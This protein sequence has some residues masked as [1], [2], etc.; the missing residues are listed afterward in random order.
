[1]IADCGLRIADCPKWKVRCA[2]VIAVLLAISPAI[3]AQETA[4]VSGSVCD[5]KGA[6]LPRTQVEVR[7]MDGRVVASAL[8]NVRGEFSLDLARGRY[9]LTAT[10]AGMAPLRDLPIR[11]GE[12]TAPL[13]LTLEVPPL[14]QQIVVTATKTETPLAQVGSDVTVI[15]GE[16]LAHEGAEGTADALRR[17]AGLT[18]SES[19]G[20]GQITSLFL[21]GGESKYTKVLIDGIA[22][23]EPGGAFNFANLSATAIDHI[24]IV[25]GP[26]SALFGSD[27]IAGVIQIF[28]RRG[29]SEGL[30]PV[31]QFL[32]EGGSFATYR[33]AA[34]IQARSRRLDYFASFSRLDTD[35][36]VP[37]G[38]FNEETIVGNLG[39]RPSTTSEIR[40]VFHSEAG[41]AGV[42]GQW[43]FERPDLDQ[44]YRHRNLAGGI[45]F[46]WSPRPAWNHRFSYT[47]SDSRQFSADPIDSGCFVAQ[48]QGRTAPYTA[49]DFPY[50]T[51]DDTRRQKVNYQSD[52]AL[53]HKNLLTAGADYERE[54]GDIGDPSANPLHAIRDNY[55]AYVQ[56]QWTLGNRL[57]TAAGVRLEHNQ[58][59]GFFAA[60]RL[61]LAVHL[62]QPAPGSFW[63]LTK[64]RA[65]FG[66]GIKEPSLVESFSDSPFFHGNPNLRPERS[67]GYDAG[68]EQNLGK[69]ALQ[70]TWFDTR[71]RDQIGFVVTDYTTFAGTF[72][73]LG[74]TRARGVETMLRQ[75]LGTHWEIAG[76]YTLLDS[77]VLES[78]SP[79][80]VYA[81]GQELLRRPRHSGSLDLRWRPRR[82]LMLGASG[83]LVGS[84]VDS[85]FSGLG[86]TR[87]PGYG[88]LNLQADFKLTESISCFAVVNN[89][90]NR[91]YME[92]LGYPALRAN[93]RIGIRAGL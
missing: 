29:E 16:E 31:P 76:A 72:F 21:R 89:A 44:Y 78:S 75:S 27:A 15:S 91:K 79:D 55:G 52:V 86:M 11:V 13:K 6:P 17:I 32:L 53:P 38:S 74:K 93:F 67:A 46:T 62:H 1:M 85:D 25:R 28:T 26:Q 7:D 8:T 54:S 58:N 87:N 68:I 73:N 19:G 77:R 80:P 61:S 66:L 83:V 88:V 33:Y 84:R 69:G 9:L 34:G 60:P 30:S 14:E 81:K 51:L 47:V 20:T 70:V 42:P 10:L 35:N 59:F 57:F 39:F 49:C 92:V 48:Y 5:Q 71:Y 3:V 4:R 90:L 45:T 2:L 65:N 82:R 63:G 24:E 37:N 36:N 43:A 41:R 23:N 40:V 12:E 50:Q 64:V 18:V 22:V 56:D